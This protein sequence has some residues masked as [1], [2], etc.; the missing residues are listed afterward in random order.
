MKNWFS[1][2]SLILVVS[3]L[4]TACGT[5]TSSTSSEE[6]T[7]VNISEI[8]KL[9]PPIIE[10]EGDVIEGGTLKVALVSNSAF[11][12]IFNPFLYVDSIDRII[13]SYTM[14][15]AFKIDSE[16]KYIINSDETPIKVNFDNDKK[17]VSYKINP[18]FKWSN[19]D[20]VT[21][22]DIVKT[23]EIA[24]NKDY[25]NSSQSPRYSSAMK[26]IV[27]IE[28]YNEGRADKISGLE[29]IDDA[30]INIHLKEFT[31][32]ILRGE[33]FARDFVN[34]KQLE[35]IPMDKI[36]GSDALRKNPLSYGPYYIE[37][38][39]SGESVIFKAN[40]YYYK[41]EPKVKEVV[42]TILPTSQ[43]VASMKSG[44]FDIYL[45]V[46]SDVYP[47]IKD[48][49]NI[50]ISASTD[51]WMSFLGFKLG[52]WDEEEGMVK[53]NPDA[54]L[55]DPELR[56]ALGMAIDSDAVGVNFYNGLR[57]KA[58]TV[59][60]PVFKNLIDPN[61][62]GI[63]YDIEGAKAILDKEGYKDV[64]NDGFREDKN[65]NPLVINFAAIGGNEVDE[66][67]VHYYM[68]QWKE[69]GININLVDGRLLDI[70]N[71]YDRIAGDDPSID[72]YAAAWGLATDPSIITLYGN[73]APFNEGRYTSDTLQK[74]LEK[75]VSKEA[76]DEEY[77]QKAYYELEKVFEDEVPVVPL[78]NKVGILP[79]NNRIKYYDD[80]TGSDFDWSMIEFTAENPIAEQ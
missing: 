49:N 28:D 18:K 78:A 72:M 27:G 8:E 80:T 17:I 10:N 66:P 16:Y 9:H 57:F 12:G 51:L 65:G 67:L 2:L 74:A 35:G 13:M 44:A 5:S 60:A 43:Q 31:P 20:P 19:G 64:D 70:N 39:V 56:R 73:D 30:N 6:A 68:Q 11:K 40:P 36:I 45:G 1:K 55:A 32:S 42:I 34:A 75:T 58:K 50:K 14:A 4:L 15:G 24:A 63:P 69:I 3:F 76:I 26:N 77:Q 38:I 62:K 23:Y 79:I 47:E 54:K 46:G 41:G 7:G 25:I 53:T 48:L 37:K 33:G 52:V 22:A 21:T 71:F 61:L 59:I 29:V